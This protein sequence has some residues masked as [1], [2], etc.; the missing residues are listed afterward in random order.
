MSS[1]LKRPQVD[2]DHFRQKEVTSSFTHRLRNRKEHEGCGRLKGK[3]KKK[4]KE[5]FIFPMYTSCMSKKCI[6]MYAVPPNDVDN[7]VGDSR[8]RSEG[9]GIV[10]DYTQ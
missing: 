2:W 7:R 6:Q 1:S 3:R 8:E 9:W 10:R 5:E 4:F